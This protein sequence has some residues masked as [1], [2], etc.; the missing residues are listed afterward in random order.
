MK[1]VTGPVLGQVCLQNVRILIETDEESTVTLDV[2]FKKTGTMRTIQIQTKSYK[3]VV[4][5][6]TN[7]EP[8]NYFYQFKDLQGKTLA[9]D[10]FCINKTED[11]L[12]LIIVSCNALHTLKDG[13]VDLW[14]SMLKHHSTT[15]GFNVDMILHI[16]DQIYEYNREVWQRCYKYLECIQ[17]GEGITTGHKLMEADRTTGYLGEWSVLPGC[18]YNMEDVKLLIK[19]MFRS[20]YRQAWNHPAMKSVI[21]RVSNQMILDDHDIRNG[22]GILEEDK[23]PETMEYVLGL[24][25]HAVYLEYQVQL[26]R[27]IDNRFHVDHRA[28]VRGDTAIF[29]MDVRNPRTFCFHENAPYMGPEQ[30]KAFE[31]TLKNSQIKNLLVVCS[32]PILLG[33]ETTTCIASHLDITYDTRDSWSCKENQPEHFAL[34]GHIEEWKMA[35]PV[36]S[37]M[38]VGGDIHFALHSVLTNMDGKRICEQVVTSPITNE[39]TCGIT[40]ILQDWFVGSRFCLYKRFN[41]SHDYKLHARNYA[42]IWK[43]EKGWAHCFHTETDE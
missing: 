11:P 17:D 16:G 23:N 2:L 31:N 24:C 35:D 43:S 15:E 19:E 13:D 5:E 37:A 30:M 10:V 12:R 21:S 20:L 6:L 3:P 14:A 41:V 36:R 9:S 39:A 32:I 40:G 27:D 38:L 42:E 25:A 29:L 34:L 22:W 4:G 8:G 18:T 33:G 7:F 1:I 28:L 26:W